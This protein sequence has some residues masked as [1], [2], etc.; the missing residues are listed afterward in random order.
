MKIIVAGGRDAE[1]ALYLVDKAIEESGM[2]K[3]MTQLVHG[4]ARGI[5]SAAGEWA[6]INNIPVHVFPADWSKYGKSAGPIRNKQMA[7][8]ADALIAIWDGISRGTK[9]MIETAES[10]N[11]KIYIYD[12][13]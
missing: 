9:H 3:D 13:S 4:A 10:M 1:P 12:Y 5:D 7:E 8:Y 2:K 11:L 6:K